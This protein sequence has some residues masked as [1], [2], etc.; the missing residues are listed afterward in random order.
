MI[1][2]P[3]KIGFRIRDDGRP[4]L[5]GN[6][7]LAPVLKIRPEQEIEYLE[8]IPQEVFCFIEIV[9]TLFL[10]CMT[11]GSTTDVAPLPG[12]L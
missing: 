11:C 2:L 4:R 6:R 10:S 9:S 7:P 5:F 1:R 12:S 8:E 3:L